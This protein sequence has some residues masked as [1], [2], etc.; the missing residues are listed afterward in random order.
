MDYA[1]VFITTAMVDGLCSSL[2]GAWQ[3]R[4][5]VCG[6]GNDDSDTEP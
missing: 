6:I 4:N 1:I 2:S 5:N 3:T